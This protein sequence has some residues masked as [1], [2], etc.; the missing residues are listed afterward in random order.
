MLIEVATDPG[1]P[2]KD[3]GDM[4]EKLAGDL[5][6]IQNYEVMSEIRIT[7]SELDLLCRHKVN[8]RQ[9]YVECKAHRSPLSAD[10]LKQLLGTVNFNH[11]Q[12][13]WLISAGALGKD[14]KGFQH[15]WEQKSTEEAQQLSIYTPER[16]VEA[17]ENAKLIQ[18]VPRSAALDM[19]SDEDI[20]GEWVLLVTPYGR[21]WVASTLRVACLTAPLYS[22]RRLG[23]PLTISKF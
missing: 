6:R 4:L 19:V 14:A 7:A 9:I 2:S 23:N 18:P 15:E 5:F 8:R 13:G 1:T 20:L 21:H 10:V 11:Y 17:L 16:V 12:E 3:K 22:Q